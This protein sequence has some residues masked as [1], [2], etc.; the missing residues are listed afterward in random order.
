MRELAA[1]GRRVA[2]TFVSQQDRSKLIDVARGLETSAAD[3]EAAEATAAAMQACLRGR[4]EML[5]ELSD[6]ARNIELWEHLLATAALLEDL[7]DLV[8]VQSSAEAF[9]PM[10]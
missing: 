7:A 4:A 1:R 9:A 3:L 8:P 6:Q 2:N 5:R 10:P